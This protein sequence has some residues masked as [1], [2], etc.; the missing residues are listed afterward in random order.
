M[1]ADG[2]LF[3]SDRQAKRMERALAKQ[4]FGFGQ[5]GYQPSEFIKRYLP[6]GFFD[7]LL[8]DEGHEYKNSGSAQGQAMG[9]LAQKSRK[10]ILLTGTLMGG[11]AD[12]LF[13]LLWRIMPGIMLEDG[14]AYNAQNSL[15][16]AAMSFMR[17]HGVLKDVFRETQDGNHR[18][19]KGKRMTVH[20]S[21]APGFGPKGVMRYVLP[22]T[23]FLK[24][25]DIGG[26]VLPTYDEYFIDVA[27]NPDQA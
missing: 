2:E 27:L 7:L 18:T 3:F 14:F 21:K 11:Y 20:T 23:A 6:D 17:E 19:A 1:D 9:V 24:L 25:K 13:Y 4:E 22:F 15:G 5:G 12:D 26:N 16:P 8:V 10:A